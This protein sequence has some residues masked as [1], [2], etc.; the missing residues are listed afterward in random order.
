MYEMACRDGMTDFH[1]SVNIGDH[2]LFAQPDTSPQ[3]AGYE[4]L[5]LTGTDSS[6]CAMHL[7]ASIDYA[8]T[9]FVFNCQNYVAAS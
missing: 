1:K 3:A 7:H 8:A 6:G 4:V 2:F 9:K 5:S